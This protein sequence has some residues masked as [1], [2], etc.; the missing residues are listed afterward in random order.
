M[1]TRKMSEKESEEE[2]HQAFKMFDKSNSG[3]ISELE[4]KQVM[5]TLG[6][7]MTD[8]EIKEMIIEADIDGDGKISFEGKLKEVQ[9]TE[10]VCVCVCVCIATYM[11]I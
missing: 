5:E 3:F 2:I 8:Q 7:K 1:M 6:E 10:C 11:G 9:E 4:L